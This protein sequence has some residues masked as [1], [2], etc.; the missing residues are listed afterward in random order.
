MRR[1]PLTKE[2]SIPLVFIFLALI[3]FC[4]LPWLDI[5]GEPVVAEH[6]VVAVVVKDADAELPSLWT[7]V[8]MS[9]MLLASI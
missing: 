2:A 4:I 7:A 9:K 1:S 8:V 3:L 5:D 6:Q